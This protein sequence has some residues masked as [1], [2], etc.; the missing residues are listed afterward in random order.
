MNAIETYRLGKRYGRTWALH[1]CTV[2]IPGGRVVALVGPNGA[3]KTTLLQ[4]AVGLIGQTCGEIAVLGGLAPGTPEAL[5]GVAFVAQDTPLYKSLSVGDTLRLVSN[6]ANTWDGA[7]AR[8][9]LDALNIPLRRK[10]GQLSGGQQAQVALAVALARHPR[11]LILD[12]PVAELDP[13]ARHDFM[14]ILM[15]AVAAEGVSV[16]FSSHVLSE[17]ER[18]CDYLI[19]LS[20]GSVQLADGTDELLA[21]H[22]V[23]TGPVDEAD[24]VG[25]VLPV[26]YERRAGRQARLLVR[27][28]NHLTV[29]AGWQVDASNLEEIVL[30]YLR[31][32]DA[33]A[34]PGPD[35]TRSATSTAVIA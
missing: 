7:H 34:L 12:E 19:L 11:L 16:V 22:R 8:A 29:P 31:S 24:A 10:V 25:A 18:V 32:P 5:D 28:T 33:S 21:A 6:L 1:D 13:L 26:V 20:H 15:E 2:A 35:P 23:L 17:L 30:S 27:T 4:L 14:S 3:G 9:R